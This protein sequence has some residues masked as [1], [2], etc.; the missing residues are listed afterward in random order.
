MAAEIGQNRAPQILVLEKNRAPLVI[1]ALVRQVSS[2]RVGIIE[3][4]CSE[5][6]ECGIRVRRSFFVCRQRQRALPHVDLRRQ[7]PRRYKQR[8]QEEM[9]RDFFH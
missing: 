7:K 5:L 6:I 8:Q 1:R 2:Q 9:P 4:A 3:A